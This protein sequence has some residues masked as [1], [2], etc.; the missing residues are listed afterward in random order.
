MNSKRQIDFF[1]EWLENFLNFE[2]IQNKKSFSLDSMHYLTKR[3]NHPEKGFKSIH[4]AGSK[5]KGSVS[6]MI[7]ALISALGYT[8]GLYN[9]PHLID[10]TE[11]ISL[12]GIP[13]SDYVYGK[14][15]DILVPLIDSI[16]PGSIPGKEDPSWFE[17][18]TLYSFVLFND[19]KLNWAVYETGLGGRLDATNVL[20]PEAS[21]ITPIE[22]EHVEYLGDTIAKIA[23]E[24]AGIIKENKPVFIGVQKQEAIDIFTTKAQSMNAN[25]FPV[26]SLQQIHSAIPQLEGLSL[27][28]SFL[29]FPN[30]PV[31]SRPITTVLK[32]PSQI[33][34]DNAALASYTVKYLFPEISEELIENTLSKVWLPGRFE[35]LNKNP[36]VVLDGAHTQKSLKS[37]LDTFASLFLGN[38]HLLFACAAD[39]EVEALA[40]LC[41]NRFTRICI[42][43][44]GLRKPSDFERASKAFTEVIDKE[45]STRLVLEVD[46]EKAIIDAFK[47]AKQEQ[48]GLLITGSFYLVAEVK[49]LLARHSLDLES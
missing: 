35:I 5:G 22:L 3:L 28:F 9:S 25:L 42:T 16:I 1:C 4:V 44:P 19:Q 7:S 41:S 2:K 24:K 32:M 40:L 38:T 39:K 14:A 45:S 36:L 15:A 12:N 17:L 11:R 6:A 49:N 29:P 27:S 10:F 21:V 8:T 48:A 37:T 31:F 20:L 13:F 23:F 33:Q 46:Y 26:G 43:K 47:T 18:V 30:G 34:A